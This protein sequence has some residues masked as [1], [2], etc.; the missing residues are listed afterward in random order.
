MDRDGVERGRRPESDQ[1]DALDDDV[2]VFVVI[3]RLVA[4]GSWP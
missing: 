2:Q 4:K 1:M 3:Q